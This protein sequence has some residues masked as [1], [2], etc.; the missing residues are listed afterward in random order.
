[1]IMMRKV[2]TNA[3]A[4]LWRP[5][6]EK[7]KRAAWEVV[8]NMK[9]DCWICRRNGAA[10]R[11]LALACAA[12]AVLAAIVVAPA[13]ALAAEPTS[14]D[15]VQ[16]WSTSGTVPDEWKDGTF[17]YQLIA[18]DGA[19]LPAGASGSYTFT[20]TGNATTSIPLVTRA[21]AA[22]GAIS[23][24]TVGNYEYDLKCVTEPVDDKMI[25]DGRE[26]HV[27]VTVEN[28]LAGDGIHVA[29]L[30]VKDNKGLKPDTVEFDPSY[31]G[32]AEPPKPQPSKGQVKQ[33]MAL[34]QTLAK[35]GDASWGLAVFSGILRA[36]GVAFVVVSLVL[37]KKNAQ[38]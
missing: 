14:L 24:D 17:T 36:A 29:R 32:E 1:M 7:C 4:A 38:Q 37:R 33:P 25:M 11:A 6:A 26:Y 21:S 31:K 23:F 22:D 18:A 8:S 19:P 28:D 3:G 20:L 10:R 15:V 35:T 13:A 16:V 9:C 30:T 2:G 12:I 5:D 27:I 34:G